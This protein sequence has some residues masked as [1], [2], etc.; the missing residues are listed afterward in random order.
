MIV[1]ITHEAVPLELHHNVDY[2]SWKSC[3]EIFI[4]DWSSVTI[5]CLYLEIHCDYRS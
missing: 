1:D 5:N 4:S 3:I 2:F